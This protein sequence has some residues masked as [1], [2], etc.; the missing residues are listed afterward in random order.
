MVLVYRYSFFV[1][2]FN[3]LRCAWCLWYS[4]PKYLCCI[5]NSYVLE[6]CGFW[7]WL[8]IR[9][10][11]FRTTWI[12]YIV[13]AGLNERNSLFFC[14]FFFLSSFFCSISFHLIFCASEYKR[15]RGNRNR[16][17]DWKQ[18]LF[19]C[20]NAFHCLSNSFYSE[21][22]KYLFVLIKSN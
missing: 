12:I 16:E 15:S 19:L 20:Q 9:H 5:A 17:R 22:W 4:K 11:W 13:S 2:H 3:F 18:E 10:S 6:T 14:L 7:C 21:C 1:I 8:D